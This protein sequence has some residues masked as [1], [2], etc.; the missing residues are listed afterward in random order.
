MFFLLKATRSRNGLRVYMA[1]RITAGGGE[2]PPGGPPPRGG[3]LAGFPL[4]GPRRRTGENTPSIP[5]PFYI[6]LPPFFLMIRRPP[7]ST[8]FP[9]TT[10]FRSVLAGVAVP[11]QDVLLVEGHTVEERLADVHGQPDH[12]G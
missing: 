11:S 6:L 4:P 7:R 8:L 9:Y 10:L 5:P 3:G 2:A 1:S 12:G